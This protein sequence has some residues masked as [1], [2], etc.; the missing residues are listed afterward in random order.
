MKKVGEIVPSKP[1]KPCSRCKK[2]LN[3]KI[4]C[5]VCEEKVSS[6]KKERYKVYE[7]NR[8][9]KKEKAFYSSKDWMKVRDM[10]SAMNPLC[11]WCEMDGRLEPNHVKPV[12]A[13]WA[14]RLSMSNLQSLYRKLSR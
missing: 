7:K 2:N 14:K 12:K 13:D 9:D 3:K 6:E 5:S 10:K 8:T 11:E 1:M 4:Y